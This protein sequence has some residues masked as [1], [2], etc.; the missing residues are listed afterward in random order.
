MSISRWSIVAR[1]YP[2]ETVLSQVE[3]SKLDTAIVR[4]NRLS[5]LPEIK[6]ASRA[7]NFPLARLT[8]RPR[9]VPSRPTGGA[10]IFC[11]IERSILI[12]TCPAPKR[13]P[14]MSQNESRR[15]SDYESDRVRALCRTT[16]SLKIVSLES[17]PPRIS[18]D[19]RIRA[20]KAAC[21]EKNP[22]HLYTHRGVV[23][24]PAFADRVLTTP[25]RWQL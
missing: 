2:F 5:G 22:R 4:A 16:G 1:R 10:G 3:V 7:T 13:M 24:A 12:R 17:P 23:V 11:S 18:S 15:H 14:K 21:A 25:I 8:R 6:C 9:Q 19:R 20:C